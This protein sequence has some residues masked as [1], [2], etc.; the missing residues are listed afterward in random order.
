MRRFST[1]VARTL[2]YVWLFGGYSG[3]AVRRHEI[4]VEGWAYTSGILIGSVFFIIAPAYL[5]TG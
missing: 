2:S 4:L 5:P 3:L 1:V